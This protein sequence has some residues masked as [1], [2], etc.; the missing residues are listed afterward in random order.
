M[1]SSRRA[2]RRDRAT[3]QSFPVSRSRTGRVAATSRLAL[4]FAER[5]RSRTLAVVATSVLIG[6]GE[7]GLLYLLVKTAAATASGDRRIDITFGFVSV[8]QASISFVLACGGALLV[9]LLCAA[10][11]NSFLGA[12]LAASSQRRTRMRL[13]A[14]VLEASWERQSTERVGRLQDLLT[15]HVNNVGGAI[16]ATVVMITSAINF[17]SFLL[18]A[19][20]IS[21]LAFGAVV[22]AAVLIAAMLRPLRHRIQAESRKN[23]R[24]SGR[25]ASDV[26][27]TVTITREIR[28]FGVEQSVL[29]RLAARAEASSAALR[30]LRFFSRLQPY[31]YQYCAL[32]LVL[33]GLAIATGRSAGSAGQLGAVVLLVVRSLSYSQQLNT[34]LQ[35]L[36]E[37]YPYL[38][39]LR[40][41]LDDFDAAAIDRSGVPMPASSQV[42]F[43][44]VSYAYGDG[45]L[46]LRDVTFSAGEGECI[47]IVGPSGSGKSTLLQVL[48]RLRAAETG[49]V[50]VGRIDA[51]RID[52]AD[53]TKAVAFVPQDNVLF[54]GTVLENIDFM[55]GLPRE[56]LVAAAKAAH[57][58]DEIELLPSGYDTLLG[59]DELDLS[60]GQR[61][62]IGLA[63]AFAGS[64]S[65]I[66]LDEPTAA[67]D[68]HSEELIQQTLRERHGSVT[69]F[70]VAHR[71][72]TMSI[73][74]RLL[75]L[76]Q[77]EVESF[78]TPDEVA[79][80]NAF[81][82]E[83][84][85]LTAANTATRPAETEA[86]GPRAAAYEA[87]RHA[88]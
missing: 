9:A 63:R 31:V 8:H 60:G 7:A 85:R 69:M 64:P 53:W 30:R 52:L 6:F 46:V 73:C 18:I 58:H 59:K 12:A 20:V 17:T 29:D 24:D 84:L 80:S 72:T 16:S 14:A 71:V 2:S 83:G 77:G 87:R 33:C 57:I 19:L 75:V 15:T 76:R 3:L 1:S 86:R 66:V 26:A 55:R 11:L 32:G 44:G 5:A 4:S 34:S 67:L 65:I 23:L 49:T 56:A 81:Y 36:N 68:M 79:T 37:S 27:E 74:D 35:S 21:P 13:A 51:N 25:F 42:E 62:R 50:Q 41:T 39:D 61:Q 40:E 78:G 28:S 38:Q 45:P 48:L 54:T 88:T 82:A 43:A 10:A 70:I 47:G 22:L